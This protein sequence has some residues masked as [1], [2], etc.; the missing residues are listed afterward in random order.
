MNETVSGRLDMLNNNTAL[1]NVSAKPVASKPCRIDDF[2]P[3][4][5]EVDASVDRRTRNDATTRWPWI[6][7][8][9][10]SEQLRRN[11]SMSCAE[12]QQSNRRE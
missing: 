9:M 5:W 10:S 2:T 7:Q 6:V 12:Q 11:F 8:M 1:Q 4:N 3:G